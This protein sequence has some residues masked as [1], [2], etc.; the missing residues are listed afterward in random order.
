MTD[1]RETPDA[2]E[3]DAGIAGENSVGD[4]G[5]SER[6]KLPFMPHEDD[7]SALGDTDQHSTA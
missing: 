6:E 7:E 4:S 2:P 5:A 3:R 1:P